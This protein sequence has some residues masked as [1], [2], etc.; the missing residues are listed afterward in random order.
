[1]SIILFFLLRIDGSFYGGDAIIHIN[2]D[3]IVLEVWRLLELR[4]NLLLLPLVHGGRA[5]GGTSHRT[6]PSKTSPPAIPVDS[7]NHIRLIRHLPAGPA[8]PERSPRWR[9]D[10]DEVISPKPA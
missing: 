4:L 6:I 10:G 8:G 7:D 3:S 9:V 5:F 2:V 1:M